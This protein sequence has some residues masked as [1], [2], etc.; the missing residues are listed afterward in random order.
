M[1]AQRQN[2]VSAWITQVFCQF[3]NT[4]GKRDEKLAKETPYYKCGPPGEE[5]EIKMREEVIS[6]YVVSQSLLSNMAEGLKQ[7]SQKLQS[8]HK[9]STSNPQPND[10]TWNN[11]PLPMNI[12]TF[13]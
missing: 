12:F 5:G 8:L 13:I 1:S 4:I 7:K 3:P 10:N 2:Q 9:A 11:K 6:E